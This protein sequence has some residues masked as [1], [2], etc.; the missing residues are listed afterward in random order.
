MIELSARLSRNDLHSTLRQARGIGDCQ[1]A[2]TSGEHQGYCGVTCS[3]ELGTPSRLFEPP[4]VGEKRLS[5]LFALHARGSA[6]KNAKVLPER[7]GEVA[8]CAR[9]VEKSSIEAGVALRAEEPPYRM[10]A[11]ARVVVD[12][13]L[14]VRRLGL[15]D[16]AVL[17][18]LP[19]SF[20]KPIELFAGQVV[21]AVAGASPVSTHC[22]GR[23]GSFAPGR[24]RY[25]R[26]SSL[27]TADRLRSPAACPRSVHRSSS[28][29]TART[30]V[31]AGFGD[32]TASSL[33][34]CPDTAQPESFMTARAVSIQPPVVVSIHQR[35]PCPYTDWFP[36][37]V[38]AGL[39]GWIA[40]QEKTTL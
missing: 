35:V 32:G 12:V 21:G 34:R 2:V 1:L 5:C 6:R 10:P 13:Q 11:N 19:A 36:H 24:R 29:R 25:Q 31:W 38:I 7:R 28:M 18:P 40:P 23:L 26:T 39:T 16:V 22:W 8:A 3:V 37:S 20:T 4:E 17:A 27:M 14:L 33:G 9:R 30:G 15:G